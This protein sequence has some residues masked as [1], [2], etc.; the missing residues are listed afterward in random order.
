MN[1]LIINAAEKRPEYGKGKLSETICKMFESYLSNDH[2][3]NH[4]DISEGYQIE[5]EREKIF[6]ADLVI[7]QFPV[8]WF[9]VPSS[10]KKY[11]DDVFAGGQFT[12]GKNGY[13]KSGILKGKYI[14][15][16]TWNA[17]VSEFENSDGL[18]VEK[19]VDDVFL[20][21][22]TTFQYIGLKHIGTLSLHD[23]MR[24]PDID[25]YKIQFQT[26]MDKIQTSID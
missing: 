18:F 4:T 19:S 25:A 21:I 14:L 20:P 1:I 23:V 26:F 17:L 9:S 24:N 3:I 10:A 15:S 12:T 8:Y 2:M 11:F 16:A 13:G 5:T 6:A 7:F 22:H